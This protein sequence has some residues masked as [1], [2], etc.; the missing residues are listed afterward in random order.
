MR[1]SG[2]AETLP[3]DGAE[4]FTNVEV[5][6]HDGRTFR[7]YDDVMKGKILL[8]NFFFTGCDALCPLVTENLVRV[9]EL[10]GARVGKDIFM[11]LDLAAAGASTR[12][13]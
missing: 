9:Q 8:I 7:F 11:Y 10:L 6:A 4:W 12:R 1:S 5:T 13:R 2:K 3:Q